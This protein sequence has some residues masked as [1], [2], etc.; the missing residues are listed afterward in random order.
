MVYNLCRF[1]WTVL[2][3]QMAIL[4]PCAKSH[5]AQM[6]MGL[7]VTDSEGGVAV[8]VAISPS[9]QSE[10]VGAIQF[11]LR[12]DAGE[13]ALAEVAAGD[14]AVQAGK[15]TLF[16]EPEPGVVRVLVAGLNMD[17]FAEGTVATVYFDPRMTDA[18]PAEFS[19]DAALQQ[20]V[21]SDE[22]GQNGDAEIAYEQPAEQDNDQVSQ[23]DTVPAVKQDAD[24]NVSEK[25]V[26]NSSTDSSPRVLSSGGP[27]PEPSDRPSPHNRTQTKHE[28]TRIGSERATSVSL[29]VQGGAEAPET[30][31]R[32]EAIGVPGGGSPP[33]ENTRAQR[34]ESR[35]GVPPRPLLVSSR[36]A[37]PA[38]SAENAPVNPQMAETGQSPVTLHNPPSV[39]AY[40]VEPGKT[41]TASV[42]VKALLVTCVT[43]LSACLMS[44]AWLLWKRTRKPVHRMEQVVKD[45][46]T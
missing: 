33:G 3:V 22:Y 43:I 39:L 20:V 8:S 31:E 4:L 32:T 44:A 36:P 14:A 21:V 34:A 29:Q 35:G 6:T 2:A 10:H 15:D 26:G 17:T 12:Y 46:T 7:P 37:A 23:K 30:A 25:P 11:D 28:R 45:D 27:L 19:Q 40:F 13:F 41:A 16:S 38:A 42:L 9:S 5:A 18:G 24:G 1:A